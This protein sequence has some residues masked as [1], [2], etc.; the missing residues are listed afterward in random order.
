MA[1]L[2]ALAYL[3]YSLCIKMGVH[4]TLCGGT[5]CKL[6]MREAVIFCPLDFVLSSLPKGATSGSRTVAIC[7][8]GMATFATKLLGW[9]ARQPNERLFAYVCT[10]SCQKL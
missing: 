8:L 7:N 1:A 9:L 2:E 6:G 4:A 3:D 5:I 10:D